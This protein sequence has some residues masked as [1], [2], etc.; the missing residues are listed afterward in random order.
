MGHR[1][2]YA[3]TLLGVARACR[4]TSWSASAARRACQRAVAALG[5]GHGAA[6]RRGR[7]GDGAQGTVGWKH[8]GGDHGGAEAR[9]DEGQ[10]A[11]HLAPLADEMRLHPRLQTRR[12]RG[13]AQVV[14]LPEHHQVKAVEVA[15]PDPLPRGEGVIGRG[16]QHQGVVEE[17][18]R[19]DERVGYRE[20]D[21][22]EVDLARC[23][24]GHQLVRTRLDHRQ[25]DAGV[26]GVELD[27]GGG[28]R[29]W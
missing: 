6:E 19:H 17:R 15:H 25:V 22:R 4:D 29:R 13:D 5:Q 21:E 18:R 28:E 8:D 9:G 3:G 23:D 14:A 7:E 24:L 2:N 16:G 12:Q 11:R 26:A 10:H 27:Q 1:G 20:H